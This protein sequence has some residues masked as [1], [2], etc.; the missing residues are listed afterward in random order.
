MEPRKFASHET[1]YSELDEVNEIIFI[2]DG[3]YNIGYEVNKKKYWKAEL[4]PST[5][6]GLF[7]MCFDK[8]FNFHYK[9]S[10]ELVG[11]VIRKK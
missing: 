9:A 8:R 7:Q 2:E 6:I 4:G 5:I 11:Y 1:I 3:E 10:T